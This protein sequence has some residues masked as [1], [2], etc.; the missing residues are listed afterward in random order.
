MAD[1]ADHRQRTAGQL[2]GQPLVVE[3]VQ[4]LEGPSSTHQQQHVAFQPC[5]GSLDG[6]Q[7][8]GRRLLPLHA[9]RVDDDAQLWGAP[10]QCG[11]HVLQRRG[12]Q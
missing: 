2:P 8:L 3:G 11:E 1:T 9:G 7:Q 10:A 4:I 5:L 12:L 6:G